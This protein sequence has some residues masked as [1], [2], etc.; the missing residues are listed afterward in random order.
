[1]TCL[2][3]FLLVDMPA[4]IFVVNLS[5]FLVLI[6]G[7]RTLAFIVLLKCVK[8]AIFCVRSGFCC[9]FSCVTCDLPLMGSAVI[10]FSG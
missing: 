1:M 10:K 2:L 6:L 7:G 8:L 4:L 9:L 3:C 5:V